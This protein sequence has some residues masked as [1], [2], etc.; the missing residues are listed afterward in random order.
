MARDSRSAS[1][2]AAGRPA[3][4]QLIPASTA[5][6]FLEGAFR[7]SQRARQVFLCFTLAAI[8]GVGALIMLGLA[9]TVATSM[10]RSTLTGLDQQRTSL[11]GEVQQRGGT[12]IAQA[13]P[14]LAERKQAAAAAL[15]DEVDVAALLKALEGATPAGVHLTG[16][17]IGST[18][19]TAPTAG[20]KKKSA[21]AAS[22]ARLLTLTAVVNSL[23]Q[24][25]E[26]QQ[27][28]T[29]V[30]LI[31]QVSAQWSGTTPTVTVT[32]TATIA[33]SALTDRARAALPASAAK[34]AGST[35]AQST[36]SP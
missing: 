16:I 25:Q 19:A 15:T 35:P 29:Q 34:S 33:D 5:F 6:D 8:M 4:L 18:A 11:I 10:D 13:G 14:H 27:A 7:A 23:P 24:V 31:N 12:A 22:T 2:P 36:G 9:A 28:L 20:S 17:T 3:T 30:T 32:V 26:L 21:P 1:A